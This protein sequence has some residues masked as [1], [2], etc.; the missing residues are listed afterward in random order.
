[1]VRLFYFFLLVLIA[2]CSNKRNIKRISY[3][4]EGYYEE[5][6]CIKDSIFDGVVKRIS[7]DGIYLGY[8][9]YSYGILNGPYVNKFSND[10]TKDSLTFKYGLR[11]GTGYKY[12]SLGRLVYKTSYYNDRVVGDTY[13]YYSNGTIKRYEFKNFEGLSDYIIKFTD[14]DTLDYGDFPNY[15]CDTVTIDD[16][17]KEIHLFLYLINLPN[18]K[19]HYEIAQVS[20]RKNIVW[21]KKIVSD[22]PFFETNLPLLS[23]DSNYAIVTHIFNKYKGRDDLT[24][25]VLAK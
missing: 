1:M 2:S 24:L 9:T 14:K 23:P 22:A 7:L 16:K 6:V 15:R 5:G 20:Q 12:D 18:V 19:M 25:Y 8:S 3:I 4:K 17:S 11:S 21:S 13:D 10:V